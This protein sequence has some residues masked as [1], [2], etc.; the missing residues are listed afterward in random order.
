[1]RLF[2]ST[3][4][5]ATSP[6][7]Y[8]H[9]MGGPPGTDGER[10]AKLLDG[11]SVVLF[12]G[13]VALALVT[14]PDYGTSWDEHVHI[15]YGDDILQYFQAGMA[16]SAVP[17]HHQFYGG[18]YNLLAAM[19]SHLVPHPR[20][21]ANHLFTALLGLIGLM[22]AWRLGRLLGGAGA[23]LLALVLLAALPAYYGH[24]FNNP[25]DLPFAVG[26]VWVLY[27]LCRL[28]QAGPK[29]PPT[30]WVALSV[31]LGL[32]MMVRIG[33]LLGLGYLT[34]VMAL[35]WVSFW[36]Q[37][38]RVQ[39]ALR[40]LGGLTLRGV[41]VA[42]AAWALMILP[43]PATHRAPL[44]APLESLSRVS[45][46]AFK[47]RTL[48]RGRYVPSDPPPWDYLPSYLMVQLPDVLWLL[49]GIGAL[50]LVVCLAKPS[51]RNALHSWRGGALS[52]LVF[53]IVF[54][55][56]YA[57]VRGSTVYDGLRHFLFVLPPL[58]VLAA[59]AGVKVLEWLGE[60]S[61]RFASALLALLVFGIA[62]VVVDMVE[63]HPYQYVY[64]NRMSGGLP[65]AANRYETE[66]YAHSFKELGDA[67]ADHLWETEPH[68]YLNEDYQILG[69]GIMDHL[70]APHVPASFSV[71][72]EP[73]LLWRPHDYDFYA[74]YRRL[75]CNE[76]RTHLPQV[77]A[78]E[79]QGVVLN[80]M[81]DM[82]SENE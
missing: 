24:M 38:R 78:V 65:A 16:E 62:V 2:L 27:Y 66:Y 67:L 33:G 70:L 10:R 60:R 76:R 15:R 7:C 9:P 39:P 77:V 40:L 80:V 55:M 59:V 79:R 75:G 29:A 21:T 30:L 18:G 17:D 74:A 14:F 48:L 4:L 32:A 5:D 42:A 53:A 81:R 46:H 8:H 6:S 54:P 64:F 19:F 58:C 22:G 37:E 44:T 34:I 1:M 20:H 36:R 43:W 57:V 45:E 11:V 69:C 50:A 13:L 71:A 51:G 82:R 23:G 3:Q 31:A 56:T 63:L 26:Y 49:L 72:R 52:L 47:T 68:R 73:P 12:A 28:I 25:K 35:Q 41:F 61:K